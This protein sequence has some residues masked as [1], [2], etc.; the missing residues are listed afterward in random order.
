MQR[1]GTTSDAGRHH[2]CSHSCWSG[3]M[4][5]LV[6][7]LKAACLATGLFWNAL[8][9][10]YCR[11]P[12][13]G[14][15]N[16]VCKIYSSEKVVVVTAQVAFSC[17]LTIII[18]QYVFPFFKKALITKKCGTTLSRKLQFLYCRCLFFASVE[19]LILIVHYELLFTVFQT[20][21]QPHVFFADRNHCAFLGGDFTTRAITTSN[22]AALPRPNVLQLFKTRPIRPTMSPKDPLRGSSSGKCWKRGRTRSGWWKKAP[23]CL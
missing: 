9:S 6:I 13:R 4:R 12:T 14:E 16:R 1:C 2:I 8:S 10:L 3:R 23:C 22:T 11:L 19:A 15:V 18:L 17:F 21:I 20:K 5:M 7:S